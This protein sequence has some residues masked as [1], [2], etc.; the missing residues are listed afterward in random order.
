[1]KTVLFLHGLESK[2]G[3]TKPTYLEDNGYCVL[4]PKLPKYSFEES[5]S[6]IH[7]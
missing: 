7:I 4:N 3:G 2:P 5:L 6:L 1:M